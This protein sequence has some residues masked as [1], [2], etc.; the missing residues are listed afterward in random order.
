MLSTSQIYH[1]LVSETG[2]HS[3]VM[4]CYHWG[5]QSYS[6]NER[7]YTVNVITLGLEALLVRL[8]SHSR[9]YPFILF[10]S[11]KAFADRRDRV[12]RVI[13]TCITRMV[14]LVHGLFVPWTVRTVPG[15]F[16]PCWER[17]HSLYSV[18]Q[19]K[20][21]LRFSDI[22]QNGWEFSDQILQAYCTFIPTVDYKFLSNYLQ[23]WRTYTILSA[24]IQRAFRPMVDISSIWWWSRLTWHSQ[25]C[26]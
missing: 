24:T 15:R 11:Y 10:A 17:Q 7:W 4:S 20:S 5:T 23:F 1:V 8:Y 18:S 14:Q 2:L 3:V 6:M 25:S 21:P 26:R 22:S 12:N 9:H 16:V 19:Q 13:T